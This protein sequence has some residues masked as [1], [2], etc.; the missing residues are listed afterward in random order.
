M[1]VVKS[2]TPVPPVRKPVAGSVMPSPIGVCSPP[3]L[4]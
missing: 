3:R 2:G 1:A 4:P